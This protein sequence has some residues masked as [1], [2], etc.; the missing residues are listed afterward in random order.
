[1]VDICTCGVH[2]LAQV[3]ENFSASWTDLTPDARNRLDL[4]AATPCDA[5]PWLENDWLHA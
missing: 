5:Y 1:M 2:T 3:Q 4:A